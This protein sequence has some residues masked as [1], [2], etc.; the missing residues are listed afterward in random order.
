[1]SEDRLNKRSQSNDQ[2][3]TVLSLVQPSGD[4][5]IGNYLGAIKNFAR[6][7]D[8]Y[9]CFFAV[10]DLHA[11]TVHQVPADIRRRSREVLAYYIA[12]GLDPN[13]AT[14]FIQSH[15]HEHAELSWVLSSL[16]YMGQL[17]RMTQWKAKSQK[18]EENLNAALFTYPVLMAA[19]ILLYQADYVPVG[20][21]QKQHLEFARDIAERFNNRYSPTFTMPEGLMPE[22]AARIMSLKDPSVKMSKS[23]DDPNAF[24]LIKDDP[25]TIRRKIAR[26]VT[27]SEAHFAYT[28]DQPGLKNLINI[29][30]A[31]DGR[32]PQEIVDDLGNISYADF[33]DLL[34]ET[35]IKTM[36][37]I[38][39]RFL[40]IT[41]DKTYLDDI[42]KNGAE[43][44]GHTAR[45]T[46]SKVFRKVGFIEHK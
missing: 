10:A 28:D 9:R 6:L 8:D 17:E 29:F 26:A 21:D 46:L 22:S 16:S 44:A 34:A 15:V 35:I 40:E 4:L 43:E 37:P 14:L 12:A 2:R 13:K 30:S 19:D 7:Q 42:F 24:I 1:M 41:A 5:T 11:I 32:K 23:D 18:N 33:K 27:D 20:E 38:R 39:D 25:D 45:R 36:S 31:Y 3:K